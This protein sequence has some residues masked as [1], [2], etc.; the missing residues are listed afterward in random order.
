MHVSTHRGL[1]MMLD[2]PKL[3]L[4]AANFKPL[5]DLGSYA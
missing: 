2:T 1:K 4:Q 5:A 3:D